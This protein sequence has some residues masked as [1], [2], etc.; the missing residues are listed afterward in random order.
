MK[1]L[2]LIL[3]FASFTRIIGMDVTVTEIEYVET[4]RNDSINTFWQAKH[5]LLR[6]GNISKY[7]KKKTIKNNIGIKDDAIEFKPKNSKNR[8]VYKNYKNNEMYSED[9][10]GFKLFTIKDSINIINWNIKKEKKEILGY[11]CTLAETFFRGRTYQAWFTTQLIAGGPWK[12]DGLPGMILKADSKD[13]YCSYEATK[14]K[15]SKQEANTFDLTNSY[16]LKKKF[17]SWSEFKKKYKEKAIKM[18]K[19]ST[20][21]GDF[22]ITPRIT[23]ERYIEEDDLDYTMDKKVREYFKK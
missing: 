4:I 9:L 6:S 21:E 17:Y 7:S 1:Y 13:G 11:V 20:A 16:T 2:I 19:F 15:I 14:I 22:S 18:S 3:V 12:F 8:L 10:I 23:R 5:Y